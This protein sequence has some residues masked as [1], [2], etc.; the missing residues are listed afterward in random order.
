M[1]VA[2]VR[3]YCSDGAGGVHDEWVDEARGRN[4]VGNDDPD[5]T[6]R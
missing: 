1:V 4:V 5:A 2:D 6:A 3:V